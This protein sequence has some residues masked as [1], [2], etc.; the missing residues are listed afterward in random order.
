MAKKAYDGAQLN[1]LLYQALE[2][3]I[4]GIQVYEN[5]IEC[6]VNDD[7]RRELEEYHEQTINHREILLSVFEAL[8]LDPEAQSP[9][10]QVVA[11]IGQ[12]LVQAIRMAKEAGDPVRAE[13]VAVECVTLA[14]TKDHMNWELIGQVAKNGRGDATKVLMQ[15]YEQVEDQEDQH[16]YHSKGWGRELWI[17]SLGMPAVLP[18]PEE[19]KHVET[20][21]GAARAEQNRDAM[22]KKRH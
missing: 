2:T 7:L 22:L 1:E 13:L 11:H 19:V 21:I 6:A 4:G 17:D 5:A 15:A 12:S 14:E 20:A 3:E 8:G 16:L 10:R 18:P 9:G